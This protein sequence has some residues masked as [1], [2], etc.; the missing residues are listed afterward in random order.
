MMGGV[1]R[2]EEHWSLISAFEDKLTLIG[3]VSENDIQHADFGRLLLKPCQK[4]KETKR[5]KNLA[6]E[7]IWIVLPFWMYCLSYDLSLFV[8]SIMC[9]INFFND[10]DFIRH[11][12][13]I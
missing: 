10:W 2:N 9:Y 12:W 4:Q 1:C 8:M 5:Q 6:R 3:M 7:T 11:S 13:Y